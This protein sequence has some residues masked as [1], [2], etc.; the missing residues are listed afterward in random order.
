MI[1]SLLQRLD[2]QARLLGEMMER[3]G[4]DPVLAV[5]E[6]SGSQLAAAALRCRSCRSKEDCRSFLDAIRGQAP[7]APGFCPNHD[8]FERTRAVPVP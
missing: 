7:A 1:D 8:F 3:L 4:V 2:M 5:R 6:A